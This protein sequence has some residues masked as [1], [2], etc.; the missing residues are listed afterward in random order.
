MLSLMKCFANGNYPLISKPTRI[1]SSTT[2][3]DNTWTNKLKFSITSAV[4]TDLVSN[5]FAIIQTTELPN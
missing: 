4:L 5:H 2:S 1:S 3:I